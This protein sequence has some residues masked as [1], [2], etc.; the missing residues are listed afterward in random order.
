MSDPAGWPSIYP[1]V[2]RST[3]TSTDHEIFVPQK[4]ADDRVSLLDLPA[5]IRLMIYQH[6]L[7][8]QNATIR[9]DAIVFDHSDP[10]VNVS[11][12]ESMRYI[13]HANRK[14]CPGCCECRIAKYNV[15]IPLLRVNKQIHQE[16]GIFFY[17]KNAFNFYVGGVW[18]KYTFDE[19]GL[20]SFFVH[21]PMENVSKIAPKYL[22]TIEK[23]EIDIDLGPPHPWMS[24]ED[25][26]SHYRKKIAEFAAAFIGNE[27]CLRDVA[28]KMGPR[29][30]PQ[31]CLSSWTY[32]L[33][34]LVNIHGVKEKVSVV[35]ITSDFAAKL[36][37]SMMSGDEPYMPSR[38]FN[39]E[40][41][42]ERGVEVYNG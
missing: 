41:E 39:L 13:S 17:R 27:H 35:G 24:V 4:P 18:S 3:R 15:A 6:C 7:L 22:R 31:K 21:E 9:P 37:A 1:S 33:D 29:L 38:C 26:Y 5:E 11:N 36:S 2:K 12:R 14:K 10:D 16:A 42:R 30:A 20:A 40:R 23:S 28:I 19:P 8:A 25:I 32:L 34:P